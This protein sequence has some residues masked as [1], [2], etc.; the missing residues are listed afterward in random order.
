MAKTMSKRPKHL[1]YRRISAAV[2]AL[3]AVGA[4]TVGVIAHSDGVGAATGGSAPSSTA[5]TI[6]AVSTCP[7]TT[8]CD[9]DALNDRRAHFPPAQPI[10]SSKPWVSSSNA[11]AAAQTLASVP[12]SQQSS[13]PVKSEQMT[14]G[15]FDKMAGVGKDP[16]IDDSRPVWVI[17]VHGP[18]AESVPPGH[19]EVTKSVYTTVID[20]P[21]GTPILWAAGVDTL[22]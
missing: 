13:L 9:I 2:G 5:A 4:V 8:Q 18:I 17:S 14:M 6:P 20:A 11:V 21:T 3:A 15:N 7:Q 16:L 12:T 19:P 1:R 22:G 10:D